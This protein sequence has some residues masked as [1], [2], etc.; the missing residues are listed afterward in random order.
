MLVDEFATLARR[1]AVA[2]LRQNWL[3]HAGHKRRRDPYRNG[4]RRT[5]RKGR[6]ALFEVREL[7][8]RSGGAV[9]RGAD[10]AV[11]T[12]EVVGL[13][14]DGGGSL[15]LRTAAGLLAPAYGVVRVDGE[16]VTGRP[17][18]DVATLGVTLL[19]AGR[20]ATGALTVLENLRL[21]AGSAFR[22]AAAR[23]ER[24]ARVI[25]WFP[26]L[27]A[28]DRAAGLGAGDQALLALAVALAR[29]PRV[30]LLDGLAADL[31]AAGY[32]AAL[33]AVRAA[34]AEGE[35]TVV[36]ADADGPDRAAL[37]RVFLV[38]GGRLRAWP[39]ADDAAY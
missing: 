8:V 37:D 27:R 5:A 7:S 13:L 19:P 20:R 4:R 22:R 17:A 16:D 38:R 18:A 1:P 36:V 2:R 33:A 29:R 24:A 6:W 28:G 14:G 35:L 32:A 11:A 34:A 30:L 39:P 26:G 21:G 31:G 12:G 25:G 23:D 3:D 9:L 10:L 15:L